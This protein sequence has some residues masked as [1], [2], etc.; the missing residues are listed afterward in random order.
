MSKNIYHNV[1]ASDPENPFAGSLRMPFLIDT[2][3]VPNVSRFED[4]VKNACIDFLISE[5]REDDNFTWVDFWAQ[6]PN[7][8]CRKYGF[9][10]ISPEHVSETVDIHKSLVSEPAFTLKQWESLKASLKTNEKCLR[11]FLDQAHLNYDEKDLNDPRDVEYFL[12][13]ARSKHTVRDLRAWEIYEKDI[14]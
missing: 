5:H 3:I 8:I 9:E 7:E 12:E 4:A 14:F 2:K 13:K 1:K 11:T 10:K 6:V